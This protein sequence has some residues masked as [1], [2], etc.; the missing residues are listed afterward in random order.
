MWDGKERRRKRGVNLHK[1]MNL[2][3]RILLWAWRDGWKEFS[4]DEFSKRRAKCHQILSSCRFPLGISSLDSPAI[5]QARGYREKKGGGKR[6]TPTSR[7]NKTFEKKKIS[8]FS[9]KWK[10]FL[11]FIHLQLLKWKKNKY[12][13][14]KKLNFEKVKIFPWK[15]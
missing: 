10:N 1:K 3:Q 12:K 7:W 9:L 11:Q 8:P 4:G 14:K 2:F 6:T 5:T 13:K 15:R